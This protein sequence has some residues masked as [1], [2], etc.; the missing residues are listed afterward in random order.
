MA[1]RSSLAQV[2]GFDD[3][4]WPVWFED[5]DLCRR[6]RAGGHR[7]LHVP[8]AVFRH[9][10]AGSVALLEPSQRALAWY[11]NLHRYAHKHHG[12]AAALLV[13]GCSVPG[14]SLRLAAALLA[15]RH[16]HQGRAAWAAAYLQVA[17][18]SLAGWPSASQSTS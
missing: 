2:G 14:A 18:R 16:P 15:A 1:R 5:V 11:G 12:R 3:G 7:L 6:L 8:A 4:F 13:R 9:Q 10:G 17:A